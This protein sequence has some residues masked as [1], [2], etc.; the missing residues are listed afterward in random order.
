MRQD[1]RLSMVPLYLLVVT[2]PNSSLVNMSRLLQLL[3]RVRELFPT[4]SGRRGDERERRAVGGSRG[5]W[6]KRSSLTPLERL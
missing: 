1:F 5:G 4:G 6:P 2:R 3:Y